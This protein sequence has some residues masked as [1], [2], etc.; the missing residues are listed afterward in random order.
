MNTL[1]E[2]KLM[3][4]YHRGLAVLVIKKM[5]IDIEQ[6]LKTEKFHSIKI[7]SGDLLDIITDTIKSQF[8]DRQ[9]K[10]FTTTDDGVVIILDDGQ[11]IEIEIDWNEFVVR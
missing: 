6:I 11:H 10:E 2:D 4:G 9:I 7:N 5:K 8:P 3:Q 1:T